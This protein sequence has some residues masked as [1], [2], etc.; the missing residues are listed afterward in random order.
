MINL[1]G[2]YGKLIEEHIRMLNELEKYRQ[3]LNKKINAKK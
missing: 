3:L 1:V 2:A